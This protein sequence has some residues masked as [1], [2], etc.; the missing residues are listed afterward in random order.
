[1]AEKDIIPTDF[2]AFLAAKNAM[3]TTFGKV[4][5]PKLEVVEAFQ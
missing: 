4:P 3:E 2:P 5:I 1:M